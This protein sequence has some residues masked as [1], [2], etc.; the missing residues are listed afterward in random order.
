M[1]PPFLKDKHFISFLGDPWERHLEGLYIG[2][3]ILPNIN[4]SRP[5]TSSSHRM[6]DNTFLGQYTLKSKEIRK[7]GETMMRSGKYGREWYDGS[8][9]EFVVENPSPRKTTY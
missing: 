3:Y 6:R 1:G 2:F 7:L 4:P 5:S 9:G 8:S